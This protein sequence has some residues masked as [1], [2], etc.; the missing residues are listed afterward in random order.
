M[1][2]EI[3]TFG[4]LQQV[5]KNLQLRLPDNIRQIVST[6]PEV[7]LECSLQS[8]STAFASDQVEAFERTKRMIYFFICFG[9]KNQ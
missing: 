1:L 5:V 2:K 3:D 6:V 9:T 8:M 7:L 4:R